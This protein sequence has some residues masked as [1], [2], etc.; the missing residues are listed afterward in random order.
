[1]KMDSGKKTKNACGIHHD[2]VLIARACT[3]VTEH[4]SP[5]QR[6]NLHSA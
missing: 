4:D 3:N 2:S 6:C 5:A 1:M